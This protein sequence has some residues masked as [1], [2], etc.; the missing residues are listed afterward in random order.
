MEQLKPICPP[1][2][3]VKPFVPQEIKPVCPVKQKPDESNS[4]LYPSSTFIEIQE[5]C[6]KEMLTNMIGN[7]YCNIPPAGC[8]K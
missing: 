3:D 4:H 7:K 5:N 6:L 8:D 2:D 1:C